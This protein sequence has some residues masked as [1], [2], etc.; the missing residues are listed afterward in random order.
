MALRAFRVLRSLRV[1]EERHLPFLETIEDRHLL[2]EIGG[3]QL[4]GRPLTL[5]ELFA[6]EIGASATLRR[7]LRRLKRLGM[8]LER[9]LERDRR[10]LEL[11]LSPRLLKIYER[12]DELLDGA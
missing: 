3:R 7:R 8:V 10:S 1:F 4:E 12:C 9:R 5:K 6:L 2:W 11:T